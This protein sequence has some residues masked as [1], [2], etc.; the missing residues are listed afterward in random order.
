MTVQDNGI[1]LSCHLVGYQVCKWTLISTQQKL[2]KSAST[3]PHMWVGSKYIKEKFLLLCLSS[4]T[5]QNIYQ[6]I[7]N[8]PVVN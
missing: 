4:V 6:M 5:V 1:F 2:Q 7:E 3:Y 8:K